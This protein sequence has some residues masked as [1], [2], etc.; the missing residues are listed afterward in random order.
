MLEDVSRLAYL[1]EALLRGYQPRLDRDF[2][3]A[4]LRNALIRQ[5]DSWL[6]GDF[7][8][9]TDFSLPGKNQGLVFHYQAS[10]DEALFLH[11]RTSE[12][13]NEHLTHLHI[14]SGTLSRRPASPKSFIL[15]GFLIGSGLAI[16]VGTKYPV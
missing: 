8:P 3:W 12:E 11:D 14:P 5:D 7:E 15:S 10:G 13:E 4:Q 1:K 16:Y 9:I 6:T 2:A